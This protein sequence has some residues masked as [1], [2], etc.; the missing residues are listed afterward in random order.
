MIA[1]F[2]LD[3]LLILCLSLVGMLL[4][5]LMVKKMGWLELLSLSFPLGAG[6][7]T[8]FVFICSWIGLP[9]TLWSFSLLLI[10]VVA[11]LLY[12]TIKRINQLGVEFPTI[13]GKPLT[14]I[15]ANLP[16]VAVWCVIAGFFFSSTI[17]AVGRS[18]SMWDSA[19][20][21]SVKGYGIVLGKSIFSAETWGAHAL[22][23]PMNIPLTVSFFRMVSG[24]LL[25]GSKFIFPLF[26]AATM[27]GIYVFWRQSH[28]PH[29]FAA[30]GTL[31]I[32]VIPVVFFHS[33]IGYA[34]L[35]LACYL[36]LGFFYSLRGMIRGDVRC[37]VVGGVL[38]GLAAWTRI[39]GVMYC[40]ALV[41]SF[42]LSRW[43]TKRLEVNFVYWLSPL[44]VIS[45]IWLI[46]MVIYGLESHAV[47][48]IEGYSSGGW[49]YINLPAI[50]GI[51]V[52]LR[53]N[54]L[55]PD[56]WGIYFLVVGLFIVAGVWSIKPRDHPE[57][58][59]SFIAALALGASTL[60]LFYVTAYRFG[61][62]FV[63][64]WLRRGFP[65]A[66]LPA[67]IMFGVVAILLV[68]R[69]SSRKA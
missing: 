53:E 56:L 15:R 14:F 21:W 40:L 57:A 43:L 60:T 11:F 8:W 52:Y 33:T 22:S 51:V 12:L 5:L 24:D 59:T 67:T 65:R 37:Q 45:G 1:A 64:G 39:E 38:L 54:L 20:I 49:R 25:P 55:N 27:L 9:V 19:A 10:I 28:V 63:E 3:L 30:L 47:L 61:I 66:F 18:Y 46:F 44:I 62:D 41:L 48:V 4:S 26:F 17:I 6:V 58:F 13:G 23:Y 2:L 16:S 68:G 42:L 36:L 31:F 69:T 34:N 32:G 7:L 50:L 35:P 29:F